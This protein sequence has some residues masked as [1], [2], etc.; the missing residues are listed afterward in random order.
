MDV[1]HAGRFAG[2]KVGIVKRRR[3]IDPDPAKARKRLSLS[4]LTPDSTQLSVWAFALDGDGRTLA[5][6]ELTIRFVDLHKRIVAVVGRSRPDGLE[7]GNVELAN[8]EPDEL[9]EEWESYGSQ[10]RLPRCDCE[11]N[12]ITIQHKLGLS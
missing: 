4:I 7:A 1:H 8:L 5:R 2:R 11:K 6:A 12:N 3:N 9:P 10:R